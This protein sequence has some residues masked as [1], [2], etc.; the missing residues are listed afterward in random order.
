MGRQCVAKSARDGAELSRS[1]SK[2]QTTKDV[3]LVRRVR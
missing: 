3:N 1:E 2:G